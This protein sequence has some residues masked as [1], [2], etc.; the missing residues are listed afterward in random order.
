MKTYILRTCGP[1]LRSYGGFQWPESGPVSAPDWRAS[2]E[3]GYG[4]H[5][6]AMGEGNGILLD[7][8]AGARWLVAEVDAETVIDLGGKVK[9]PAAIVVYCGDRAGA[10]ADIVARGADPA[11]MVGGTATA[12]AGGTAMVGYRGTATAGEYGTATAGYRGTATAGDGGT[13]TAGNGGTATAG[14]RGTAT[15]GEYGTATAGEYGTATAGVG[16]TATAGGRGTA[17][18]G[19]RGTVAVKWHD[20]ARHRLAVGY[21]GE[22]GIEANVAYVV[23]GGRLAPK[24]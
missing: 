15:A 19:E 9:F 22:N 12:G 21:V 8:N 20:G 16:G 2:P 17:T 18:A 1:D 10:V 6:L 5:G 4:L 14:Y 7:W 11:K 3:C 13:A 24:S 23:R